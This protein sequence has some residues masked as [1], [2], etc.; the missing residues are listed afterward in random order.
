MCVAVSAGTDGVC[1]G[2]GSVL[3]T[4]DF[5]FQSN[6]MNVSGRTDLLS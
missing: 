1:G 6:G 4:Y 2:S 5:A 3:G